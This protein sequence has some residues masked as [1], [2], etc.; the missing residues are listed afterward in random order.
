MDG[1]QED[2]LDLMANDLECSGPVTDG[3]DKIYRGMF[4]SQLYI[5]PIFLIY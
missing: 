4:F 3:F 5:R 2:F 1:P